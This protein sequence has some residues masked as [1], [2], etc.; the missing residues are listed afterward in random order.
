VDLS[1]L[2]F[3]VM[4]VD[5]GCSGTFG[6]ADLPVGAAPVWFEV[7][8]ELADSFVFTRVLVGLDSQLA[9]TAAVPA[10][11]FARG[12]PLDELLMD[13]VRAPHRSLE[14]SV[15]NLSSRP[16]PFACSPIFSDED[17]RLARY[18]RARVLGLG[19]STIEPLGAMNVVVEPQRRFVPDRIFV[20]RGILE[21]VE[22]EG[23]EVHDFDV[24]GRVFGLLEA[25]PPRY[26]TR[27]N[28]EGDGV[29]HLGP[30]RSVGPRECLTV[31]FRNRTDSPV[32]V[33]GAVLGGEPLT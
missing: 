5:A 1:E 17:S 19:V 26:L 9:S 16:L 10:S 24:E 12:A 29:L 30:S 31:K 21:K 4:T 20:P 8:D 22:V 28:L 15:T 14:V 18:R 23:V 7:P 3:R 25:V 2:S 6:I 11:L 32:D 13:A 27:E 33:A